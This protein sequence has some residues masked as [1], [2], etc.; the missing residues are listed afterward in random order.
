MKDDAVDL[1][2]IGAGPAGMAAAVTASELGLSV[3]VFD[4]QAAPGGQIYRNAENAEGASPALREA[5]GPDYLS[6]TDYIRAFRNCGARFHARTRVWDLPEAGTLAVAD[7][8]GARLVRA[9]RILIASGAMERPV[10]LP[11]W[12]LPGVMGVGAAQTLL[13]IEGLV[14]DQPYVIAGG[15]PLTLL[16]AVQLS[17]LGQP[18]AALLLTERLNDYLRAA[19]HWPDALRSFPLLT[20]GLKWLREL[21]RWQVLIVRGVEDLR[22]EGEARL[23][24]I[25]WRKGRQA[26]SLDTG[27]LLLHHG[28]TPAFELAAVA[29]CGIVWDPEQAAWLPKVDRWGASTRNDL[30]VAGD[31]GGIA[32]AAAAALTGSLAALDAARLLGRISMAERDRRAESLQSGLAR[33]RRIRPFLDALYRPPLAWRRPP[34]DD[35]IVCRCESVSAGE[36]RAAVRLGC[37]GPNQIKSFT[38]CG[39]G[40]CQGRMCA[41]AVAELIAEQTHADP[42]QVGHHRIRPPIKPVTVA[43]VASLEGLD[44]PASPVTGLLDEANATTKPETG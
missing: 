8:S 41:F 21:Q 1:A 43:E 15:G 36:I 2:I 27:L 44:V 7:D 10:P 42:G 32:G 5:L 25:H 39:M 9:R 13:K 30:A 26:A 11:G 33:E 37:T 19:R 4:E 22:A 6:G 24:R 14:P 31:A 16:T 28:V 40:P 3:A 18:P 34:D 38:R 23:Q 35:T 12:T 29:E 20:K 17:R